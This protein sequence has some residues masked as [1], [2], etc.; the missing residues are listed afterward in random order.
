MVR[1]PFLPKQPSQQ[2]YRYVGAARPIRALSSDGA[3]KPCGTAVPAA[4]TSHSP[5]HSHY[6]L[7]ILFASQT[8]PARSRGQKPFGLPLRRFCASG[9]ISA[10]PMSLIRHYGHK[11]RREQILRHAL[12][13]LRAQRVGLK[14]R[15]GIP[16]TGYKFRLVHCHECGVT[17]PRELEELARASGRTCLICGERLGDRNGEVDGSS[18][19]DTEPSEPQPGHKTD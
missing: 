8:S 7:V 10:S 19:S 18:R 2:F 17:S 9:S 11:H 13:P 3:A 12:Q 16:M 4:P 5:S 1:P 15:E 14:R 6:A